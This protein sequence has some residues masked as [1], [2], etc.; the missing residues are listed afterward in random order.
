MIEL[1]R[2]SKSY[3]TY[4]G[5]RIV[6]DDVNS[7]FPDG[8]SVGILGAN[9]SGKSTLVRLLS[10]VEMPDDGRVRRTG[11]VSFPLGF[12]GTFHP[13]LNGLENVRFLARVHQTDEADAIDFVRAF[14]ELDDYFY[15]PVSTYSSGMRA[16]LAFG[17]CL[18]LDFD[19]YL[20][21]EVT[22]VGDARFRA[23]CLAA[24]GER[25]ERS[26]V[27]MVSHDLEAM[28]AYCDS[29]AV[30]RQGS[31]TMYSTVN[32]AIAAHEAIMRATPSTGVPL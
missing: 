18:A 17:A 31:L 6:L 11:R 19:T 25:M 3:R 20:I 26:E 13:D 14:A 8:V 7:V 9:G 1:E 27:V 15:M 16:R 21:D 22:A 2:V 5:R 23:R 4:E 32:E 24:F 12:S 28:R 10:G 29:G 30:L